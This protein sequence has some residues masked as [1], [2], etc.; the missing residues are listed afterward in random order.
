MKKILLISASTLSLAVA[1]SAWADS[2]TVYLDQTG[3]DQGATITQ[4]GTDNTVGTS[5]HNNAFVQGNDTSGTGGNVLSV[6]Q[7]GNNNSV[8]PG[9]QQG[10]DNTANISQAGQYSDVTLQQAGSNNGQPAS[11]A[12]NNDSVY[13]SIVQDTTAYSSTISLTQNGNSNVFDLA[14]G[15]TGNKM[16]VTQD[17][18]DNGYV[19]VRQSVDPS[20]PAADAYGHYYPLGGDDNTVWVSQSGTNVN[21]AVA[22]QGG[23]D[24]NKLAINQNGSLLAANIWQ[25]GSD[26]IANSWQTGNN[27][28]IGMAGT[29]AY[30]NDNPF[31]QTGNYNLLNSWQSGA[32]NNELNGA[33]FGTGNA[34]WSAQYGD[35][36]TA[37][38]NQ[39]TSS[40]YGNY[41][42]VLNFQGNNAQL[43]A[44]QTNSDGYIYNNQDGYSLA[45]ITQSGYGDKSVGSQFGGTSGLQNTATVSQSGSYDV[46]FYS[47]NGS[48]N[49][50]TV[51]QDGN[52]NM[53]STTQSGTG[54]TATVTQ[55]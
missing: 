2:N 38:I 44:S 31:V 51:I 14:Q 16:T 26:N 12:W 17:V 49:S 19:F 34:I 20:V 10:T 40:N 41:N 15:G 6:T 45:T 11:P 46:A 52:H 30:A 13:N 1:S 43:V 55:H 39:D 27:N 18:N 22:I 32:S 24:S 28:A 50:V 3:T 47:Q 7:T 36:S 37:L 8:M 33:Q 25:N 4:S 29:N 42:K 21:Y 53:S 54:N 35:G 5:G 48:N 23:G 9:F